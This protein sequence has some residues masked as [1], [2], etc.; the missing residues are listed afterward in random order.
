MNIRHFV[1]ILGIIL[2]LSACAEKKQTHV[3]VPKVIIPEDTMAIILSEVQLTEAYLNQI[4]FNLRGDN[5]SDY[6]YFPLLFEKYRISKSDFLDNLTYYSLN[7]DVITAIYDKS[8]VIL[9][10]LKAIDLEIRLQMK[11]D[12]IRLDSIRIERE[13]FIADSLGEITLL[14]KKA[15]K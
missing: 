6:V 9:N 13:K 14:S 7:E 15:K 8:I 5:D 4:P 3:D 1:G 11:L 12:S 10:K 2:L